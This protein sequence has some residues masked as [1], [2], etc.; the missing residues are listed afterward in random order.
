MGDRNGVYDSALIMVLR[1]RKNTFMIEIITKISM[2]S[3]INEIKERQYEDIS[4]KTIL[5]KKSIFD[6]L[7]CQTI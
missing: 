2:K 7:L 6:I 3:I 5:A 4:D 1:Q